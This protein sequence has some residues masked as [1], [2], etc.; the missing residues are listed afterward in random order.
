MLRAL[1]S[2]ARRGG[3]AEAL[4]RQWAPALVA[5]GLGGSLRGASS[6]SRGGSSSS[7]ASQWELL[8]K[9]VNGLRSRD[10]LLPG[11]AGLARCPVAVSR[12]ERLPTRARLTSPPLL[13]GYD[14]NPCHSKLHPAFTEAGIEPEEEEELPVQ[15]AYTPESTCFGCGACPGQA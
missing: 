2:A 10:A 6:Y 1:A 15:E 5:H 14:I 11:A 3:A 7:H 12:C 8:A 13:Q 4:A 9:Q